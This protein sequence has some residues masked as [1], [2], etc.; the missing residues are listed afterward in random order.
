MNKENKT[1]CRVPFDSVTVSPTGR[2]QLCCEAQ[3]TGGTEKTKLKDV[4]SMQDW[5]DGDYLKSVRSSMLEGRAV[6]ECETCYKRERI[7][8]HSSRTFV[9][10]AYFKNNV[11]TLEHSIKKIDLKLGN[12]CNLKCKMCFP[13]ASSELWKEWKELGWNTKVKD[14]NNKSSWK[15]YDGYF[16]EDYNW[17]KN[18]NNMDKIKEA[19]LRS[20]LL[21]VTGGEPMLN[22]EFFDILKHCIGAGVSKNIVLDVTTNA[23]KIHPR[24]FG[25]AS[26]FKNLK[27]TISMDGI[28]KTYEYIRYPANYQKVYNNIL[29]Y[30]K[31]VKSLGNG[32]SLVFNFVLQVWNIH[33]TLDVIKTLAPLS[34]NGGDVSVSIEEL[35]DP[36]F[37]Q[38]GMTGQDSIKEVTKKLAL[39]RNTN[40]D[41]KVQWS[42]ISF[43][44]ILT[45][46]KKYKSEIYNHQKNQ[47][48]EFTKKQDG[49]RGIS[50]SDYIPELYL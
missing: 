29:E 40:H 6:A 49:H 38:W 26:K 23:T 12:K 35:E 41:K 21:H 25:M 18:K 31:F 28:G 14:P 45:A 17:P 20:S 3:W 9:N 19:V 47:L 33:N 22:P 42:I 7:H 36:K 37:M 11:D 46:Y 5:F 27:L 32:S 48:S 50:L 10:K 16:D 13:Y 4:S 1:Y 44:K 15:Y 39:E 30:N 43:S 24:F 8:G 34:V 2:M